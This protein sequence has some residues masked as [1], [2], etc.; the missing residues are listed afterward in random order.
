MPHIC[1][2]LLGAAGPSLPVLLPRPHDRGELAPQ[3]P[4][5]LR[6]ITHTLVF[7]HILANT[8]VSLAVTF[9]LVVLFELHMEKLLFGFMGLGKLLQ[10]K[11]K[12]KVAV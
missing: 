2:V 5:L 1:L 7:Y 12:A 4:Q 6:P 11:K 8:S 3:P 10:V 9:V